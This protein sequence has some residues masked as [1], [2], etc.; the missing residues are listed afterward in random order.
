M[1][2]RSGQLGMLE[3]DNLYLDSVGRDTFF[4]FLA[5]KRGTPFSDEESPDL[6][7]LDNGRTSL[8]PSLLATALLLQTYDKVS[9]EE[10]KARA[11]FDIRWKVACGIE[12]EDRPFAKSTL[13]VFGAQLILQEEVISPAPPGLYPSHTCPPMYRCQQPCYLHTSNE[14]CSVR[15]HVPSILR[16]GVSSTHG[17][18]VPSAYRTTLPSRTVAPVPSEL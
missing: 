5:A 11:D 10:T 12:I 6:C 14:P 18:V 17:C 15:Y 3:A 7:C 8:P 16:Q 13:Q 1:R 9:D 2:K 4:G